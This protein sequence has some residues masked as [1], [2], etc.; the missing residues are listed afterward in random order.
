MQQSMAR[1]A[2]DLHVEAKG[3]YSDKTK[4]IFYIRGM[5][6]T[7]TKEEITICM[8][9][10]TNK[11]A[12]K[13]F[14]LG[15]LRPNKNNTL[16]VTLSCDKEMAEMLAKQRNIRIGMVRCGIEQKFEIQ[17]CT[18]CWSYDHNITACTGVD[19]RGKCF[20]CGG[21]DHLARDCTG[22]NYCQLCNE[23]H[24]TGTR[25]CGFFRK[26]LINARK[27]NRVRRITSQNA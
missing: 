11:V 10:L 25:E 19:R 16:A 8:E 15:E 18:K 14:A 23:K 20:R 24:K 7:T 9:K 17:R 1:G 5:D 22:E 3:P 13:D 26:A 6:C 2:Q 27:E 4:D 21:D 12:G